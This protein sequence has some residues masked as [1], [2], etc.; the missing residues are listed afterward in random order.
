MSH[1]KH[2]ISA[3]I[4]LSL[5]L[6]ALL[7]CKSEPSAPITVTAE[8]LFKAYQAD[9]SAADAKY[10]GES[11]LVTGTVGKINTVSREVSFVNGDKTIIVYCVRFAPDQAAALS[12]LK[13]GQRA[14]V[15][16]TCDGRAKVMGMTIDQVALKDS[17]VQ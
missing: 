15:K 3:C 17:V 4:L 12:K 6:A 10:K 2:T 13:I 9:E 5:L 8:A 14:T 1:L 11:V 7:A 16:G